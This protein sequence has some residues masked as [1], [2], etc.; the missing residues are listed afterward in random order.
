MVFLHWLLVKVTE[1][2]TRIASYTGIQV[3]VIN[4]VSITSG[5][6]GR[7]LESNNTRRVLGDAIRTIPVGVTSAMLVI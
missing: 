3:R 2:S 1:P 5:F 6:S 4:L 7:R